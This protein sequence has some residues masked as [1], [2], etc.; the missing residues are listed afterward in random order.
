SGSGSK[1]GTIEQQWPIWTTEIDISKFPIKPKAPPPDH[2][3]NFLCK[4][5]KKGSGYGYPNLSIGPSYEY[6]TDPFDLKHKKE[7][8]EHEEH[9]KKVVGGRPFISVASKLEYFNTFAPLRYSLDTDTKFSKTVV[10]GKGARA[11]TQF[12]VPFKPPSLLGETINKYPSF[13]PPPELN[14]KN[15]VLAMLE[16]DEKK[17]RDN[18]NPVFK[19]SGNP[20]SYPTR[21][22]IEANTPIV[23]PAWIQKTMISS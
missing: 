8:K 16:S 15:E 1:Y 6:S 14:K 3:K 21:S 2:T 20:K 11:K 12:L 5:P 10:N 17:A 9:K 18:L 22:I 4:P 7:L 23:M 13:E 19:P